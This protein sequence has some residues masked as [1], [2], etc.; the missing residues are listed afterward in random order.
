MDSNPTSFSN[1]GLTSDDYIIG[2][3]K[4][5]AEKET[6]ESVELI[7]NDNLMY[8]KA[9]KLGLS[10]SDWREARAVSK[11]ED[12]FDG[13]RTV[14][15]P[16][17]LFNNLNHAYMDMANTKIAGLENLMPNEYI[18]F[19]DENL[20]ED[21][22]MPSFN[23]TNE[24]S[25]DFALGRYISKV[26]GLENGGIAPIKTR[27]SEKSSILGIS[28]R[29]YEQAFALD[30]LLDPEIKLVNI[31]GYAGTGKTLISLAAGISMLNMKNIPN[32]HLYDKLIATRIMV[33]AAGE[34][35]GILPGDISEK[36]APYM[37]PIY[38]NL[39]PK[40]FEKFINTLQRNPK[41]RKNIKNSM[42]QKQEE[43]EKT[44]RANAFK[45]HLIEDDRLLIQPLSVIRGRSIDDSYFILTEGQNVSPAE[46]K[47][48]ITR[49]GENT[50]VVIEGDRDQIDRKGLTTL[51]NGLMHSSEKFKE[52]EISATIRLTKGERSELATLGAKLL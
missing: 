12:S 46:V 16:K 34:E 2:T 14:R 24:N 43:Y 21:Y 35:L 40:M 13:W 45:E 9:S 36:M 6:Y 38:D 4:N 47:T 49:A 3:A 29:N 11:L 26:S 20:P 41:E 19:L 48:F 42:N 25:N 1:E 17:R 44:I 33:S 37:A 39:K 15:A 32:S 50:K 30:A 28:A 31:I 27:G 10:V 52:Q 51:I 22:E 7:T 5:I 23:G 18:L 8:I